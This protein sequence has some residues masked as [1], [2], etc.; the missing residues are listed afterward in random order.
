MAG[1]GWREERL[2]E[3]ISKVFGGGTPSRGNPIYRSG[4]IPWASVKTSQTTRWIC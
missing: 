4:T 1:S 3:V 2:A